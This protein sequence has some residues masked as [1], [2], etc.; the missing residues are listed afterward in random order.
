MANGHVSQPG[1]NRAQPNKTEKDRKCGDFEPADGQHHRSNHGDD[2]DVQER[3][4]PCLPHPLQLHALLAMGV[5][6]Y[7]VIGNEDLA[8]E[9]EGRVGGAKGPAFTPEGNDWCILPTLELA[10]RDDR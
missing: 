5:A 8:T 9:R 3:A 2:K 4:R 7:R 6:G 10:L 1:V